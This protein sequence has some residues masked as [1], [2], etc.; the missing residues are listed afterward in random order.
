MRQ[1]IISIVVLLAA[2]AGFTVVNMRARD[3]AKEGP[4]M[5]DQSDDLKRWGDPAELAA[6]NAGKTAT[7]TFAIEGE[8]IGDVVVEFFPE[9]APNTVENFIQLAQDG[10][11]DGLVFHRVIPGFMIQGGDP[12]GSGQG[13][14]G[15]RLPAE[16][17]SRHHAPGVLAMAR[18]ADPDSAGSQ[19]YICL[20]S[21][22]WLDGEYTIFGQ[23]IS[24]EEHVNAFGEQ[25]TGR[26][27]RPQQQ[28]SMTRVTISD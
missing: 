25:A 26:N 1:R 8:P 19:F 15:W 10:Y 12:K 13:G 5:A 3:G 17:N 4:T 23:V 14:P 28:L 2:I 11:Y 7:L 20:G 9:D 21:P 22:T 16:F 18:T 27:D 6:K 24:G